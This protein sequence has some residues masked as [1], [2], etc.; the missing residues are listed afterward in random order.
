M[1]WI[2]RQ[3]FPAVNPSM[4]KIKNETKTLRPPLKGGHK[5]PKMLPQTIQNKHASNLIPHSLGLKRD[6][7]KRKQLY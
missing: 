6:K 1:T 4:V 7:Y 5:T 2:K 3:V